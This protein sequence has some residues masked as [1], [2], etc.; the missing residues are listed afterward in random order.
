MIRLVG[1][2]QVSHCRTLDDAQLLAVGAI[3]ASIPVLLGPC[4]QREQFLSDVEFKVLLSR[5]AMV[6]HNAMLREIE[7]Y[8]TRN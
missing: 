6:G 8:K 2:T 3:S 7:T 4:Y 5:I 1:D